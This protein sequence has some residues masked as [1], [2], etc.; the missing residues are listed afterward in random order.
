VAGPRGVMTVEF[1]RAS[2][3]LTASLEGVGLVATEQGIVGQSQRKDTRHPPR[4]IRIPNDEW[5]EIVI[6]AKRAG[7]SCSEWVRS[8]A[9]AACREEER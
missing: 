5:Q 1:D 7:V 6:A 9:V 2:G 3:M 8:H 4:S